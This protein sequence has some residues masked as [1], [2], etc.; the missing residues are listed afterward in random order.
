MQIKPTDDKQPDLDALAALLERRRGVAAARA[1]GPVGLR[2]RGVDLESLNPSSPASQ[3]SRDD[4]S[5]QDRD[6]LSSIAAEEA[7][8]S[9]R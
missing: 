8:T 5:R 4:L 9:P 6:W 7:P 3:A 1:C 2:R